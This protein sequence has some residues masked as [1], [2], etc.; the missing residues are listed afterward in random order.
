MAKKEIAQKWVERL[1]INSSEKATAKMQNEAVAEVEAYGTWVYIFADGSSVSEKR[2]GD[3]Y[4]YEQYAQ[5]PNCEE[6]HEF[7]ADG[8]TGDYCNEC[9]EDEADNEQ[10]TAILKAALI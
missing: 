2:R 7:D 1:D 9:H 4:S 6:W 10:A 3:W 5:C 8:D